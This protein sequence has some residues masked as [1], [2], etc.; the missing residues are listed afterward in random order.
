MNNNFDENKEFVK[1]RI[2]PEAKS[3]SPRTTAELGQVRR[4]QGSATAQRRIP[5]ANGPYSNKAQTR[6]TP[7]RPQ[8]V[9][10]P[11]A[12]TARPADRIPPKQNT[13]PKAKE[14][15]RPINVGS[16][17]KN[18]LIFL[19][20]LLSL[21]VLGVA[22][23]LSGLHVAPEKADVSYN[24]YYGKSD[25]TP[26]EAVVVNDVLYI[27]LSEISDMC[28]FTVS[29]TKASLRYT[30]SKEEFIEFTI[31][32]V[33][34][35]I[36]GDI[37]NMQGAAL[38]R[39]NE[40]VWIPLSFG[41]N[42]FSGII[43]EKNDEKNSIRIMR[44]IL[45][46]SSDDDPKYADVTFKVKGSQT[47]NGVTEDPN[48]GEYVDLDFVNDLS[49]YEQYMNPENHDEYLVLVNKTN[50]ISSEDVPENLVSIVDVRRDGRKEQM[51]EC[52][53]KALEAMFIELRSAGFKDVSV[54][55]GYRSYNKQVSLFT[56]YLQ[57]E[58][59]RD[60]S[61]TEAQAKEIVLTYSAFPGTS[62]HQTG[63]CCDMHNLPSA[64]VSFANKEAYAWLKENCHKF[65]FIIRFPEDKT[66]IT[67]YSF[68]PWHYRFVGRYHATRMYKLDMCL[69]EYIEHLQKAQEQ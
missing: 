24:L 43:F 22:L 6:P 38:V 45:P 3:Q 1:R 21:L 28:S 10:K 33:S 58:M 27:N 47:L 18:A 26:S 31:G 68:E 53:E 37:V 23:L 11:A 55:S 63:L 51:V 44:E 66:E 17:V 32:S 41:E 60:P 12:P 46:E 15:K 54:T 67:G 5:P 61:L 57:N 30:A 8:S 48:V 34:A 9:K 25:K 49:E 64:D 14:E 62:E 50:S 40:S 19:A 39:E 36:N 69:E 56:T 35:K 2:E 42:Y 7:P 52:A 59:A 20:M 4:P 16:F 29:G 13:S 65:G